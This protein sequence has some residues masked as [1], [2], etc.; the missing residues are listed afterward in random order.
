LSHAENHSANTFV[1]VAVETRSRTVALRVPWR[2]YR[3]LRLYRLECRPMSRH[4]GGVG[5]HVRVVA[6]DQTPVGISPVVRLHVTFRSPLRYRGV[7][8]W[9]PNCARNANKPIP[10]E[11]A[12]TMIKLNA[13]RRFPSMRSPKRI[14]S[15][16]RTTK[17]EDRYDYPKAGF[18]P[19]QE[20]LRIKYRSRS[21]VIMMALRR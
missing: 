11:F 6:S 12:I 7:K 4:L 1:S 18:A 10:V 9:L 20:E 13:P 8:K 21:I 17:I 2:F 5:S 15:H 16:Q 19:Q 3:G 14:T